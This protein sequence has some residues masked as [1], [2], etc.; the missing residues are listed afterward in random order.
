MAALLLSVAI[1]GLG[2]AIA[3]EAAENA[4]RGALL[5][6]GI[7]ASQAT[8]KAAQATG[9]AAL[10]SVVGAGTTIAEEASKNTLRGTLLDLCISAGQA[11]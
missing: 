6:F 3:K 5:D 8:Q 2:A 11:T 10:L 1:A 9:V 4:L 7:S